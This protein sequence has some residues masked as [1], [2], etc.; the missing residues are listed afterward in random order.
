MPAKPPSVA[1]T[2]GSV[3]LR[4]L[5]PLLALFGAG[6][7]VVA[8]PPHTPNLELQVPDASSLEATLRSPRPPLAGLIYLASTAKFR[9]RFAIGSHVPR[10]DATH[11]KRRDACRAIGG[12]WTSRWADTPEKR[13]RRIERRVRLSSQS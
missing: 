5:I 10:R 8:G 13:H 6:L 3:S 1:S 2:D 7:Y 11:H 4:V 12:C 9:N